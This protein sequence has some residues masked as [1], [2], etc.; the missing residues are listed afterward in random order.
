MTPAIFFAHVPL[1]VYAMFVGL[2]YLGYKCCFPRTMRVER[3]LL[4]PAFFAY[5]SLST[6]L[7][8]FHPGA[9]GIGL[10]SHGGACGMLI[11]YLHVRNQPIRADHDRRLI[12]MPA[13]RVMPLLI[14][15]IFAFQ[16]FLH[17][18]IEARWPL[19]KLVAF[20]RAAQFILGAIAG[21]ASGR[22]LIR[23]Y[24]YIKAPSEN[25]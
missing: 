15:S 2:M 11:G 18:C 7:T 16:L 1:Y 5:Q 19:A 25:L 17:Y 20:D 21:M 23:G 14:V 10:W 24:M 8:L 4:L 12:A 9:A 6:L 13:D 22:N 3:L